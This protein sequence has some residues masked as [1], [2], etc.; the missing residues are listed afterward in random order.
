MKSNGPL[1]TYRLHLRCPDTGVEN[2]IDVPYKTIDCRNAAIEFARVFA[3]NETNQE[4]V[5]AN[6]QR[7]CGHPQCLEQ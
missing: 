3:C 2:D 1:K 6:C 5:M 7:Y 4:E